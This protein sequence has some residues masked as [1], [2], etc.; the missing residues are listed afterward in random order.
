[1]LTVEKPDSELRVCTGKFDFEPSDRYIWIL[2]QPSQKTKCGGGFIFTYPEYFHSK[3][4]C[5]EKGDSCN[6]IYYVDLTIRKHTR[7]CSVLN[8]HQALLMNNFGK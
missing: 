1:M 4:D 7:T 8:H 2:G 3:D 5:K 6:R